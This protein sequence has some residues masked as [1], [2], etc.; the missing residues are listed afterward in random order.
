[1]N[2]Q[3]GR[4]D[5]ESTYSWDSRFVFRQNVQRYSTLMP[6]FQ[7]KYCGSVINLFKQNVQWI[8]EKKSW[9]LK[10]GAL[11]LSAPYWKSVAL[12]SPCKKYTG[13]IAM[14]DEI[15]LPE[16]GIGLG[17]QWSPPPPGPSMVLQMQNQRWSDRAHLCKIFC[18]HCWKFYRSLITPIVLSLRPCPPSFPFQLSLWYIQQ[19]IT[20]KKKW[21]SIRS[22][23]GERRKTASVAEMALWLPSDFTSQIKHYTYYS[24]IIQMTC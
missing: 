12:K 19:Y 23:V 2:G 15:Q 6:S 3:D 18:G 10:A 4:L 22:Q 1:M 16:S 13:L 5:S 21:I 11:F 17:L 7:I 14:R 24:I 20:L 9:K 8:E